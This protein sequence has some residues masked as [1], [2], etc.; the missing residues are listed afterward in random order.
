MVNALF[1][2]QYTDLCYGYNAFWADRLPEL[3]LDAKASE[4]NR[5]L[6]GDDFEVETI[7][8][9][10]IAEAGIRIVDVP[11][12]EF[13]RLHGQSNLNTWRMAAVS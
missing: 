13:P 3:E 4:C 10:R 12:F 8:N 1:G 11:S 7:I 6:W 5:R 2:T 9:T